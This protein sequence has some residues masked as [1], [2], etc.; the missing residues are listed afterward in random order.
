VGLRR[1][2]VKMP[3][4]QFTNFSPFLPLTSSL[5]PSPQDSNISYE[6]MAAVR[7]LSDENRTI[8]RSIHSLTHPPSLPP[9][10]PPSPFKKRTLISP[11]KSWPPSGI[12]PTKTAPSAAPSTSPPSRSSLSL[13]NSSSWPRENK[14]T[15]AQLT[16]LS[17]ISLPPLLTSCSAKA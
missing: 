14:S 11:T 8:C 13:I 17:N 9:S 16:K 5:P 1:W 15:T 10:L 12:W 3:A 6:V 4:F 7:N 2:R